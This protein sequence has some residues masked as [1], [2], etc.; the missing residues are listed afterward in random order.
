MQNDF[1]IVNHQIEHDAD[2]GAAIWIRRE[3]M[4]FD[5]TRMHQSRLERAQDRIESLDVANLKDQ[6]I[7][8]GQFRQLGRV[9]GIFRDRFLDQ[10]MSA[11]LQ[12]RKRNCMVEVRWRRNRSGVHQL[13]KFIERFRG[14]RAVFF[15]NRIPPRKIDIVDRGEIRRRNFAIEPRVI[16][17]DMADAHDA[18][19]NFFHCCL[20]RGSRWLP[21]GR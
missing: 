8:R 14:S 13:G 3:S 6:L 12:K 19:A 9:R 10:Q 11:T 1:E 2:V 16:A 17:S 5:E 7:P 15:A 18:N 20:W 21:V 4:R